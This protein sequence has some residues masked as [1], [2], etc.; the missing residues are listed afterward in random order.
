MKGYKSKEKRMKILEILYE[1]KGKGVRWKTIRDVLRREFKCGDSSIKY[2]LDELIREGFVEKVRRGE[3]KITNLGINEYLR[4]KPPVEYISFDSS[5]MDI[6]KFNRDTKDIAPYICILSG[7]FEKDINEKFYEY[8]EGIKSEKEKSI[9]SAYLDPNIGIDTIFVVD[10][11]EK[12]FR[13]I[14]SMYNYNL[15]KEDTAKI[16]KSITGMGAEFVW[17]ILLLKANEFL[18]YLNAFTDDSLKIFEIFLLDLKNNKGY[19]SNYVKSWKEFFNEIMQ[20]PSKLKAFDISSII[21][22]DPIPDK[23]IK[24]LFN[25]F[26]EKIEKTLEEKDAVVEVIFLPHEEYLNLFGLLFK[27]Y[28]GPN[29]YFFIIDSRRVFMDVDH[30]KRH[31]DDIVLFKFTE[32]VFRCIFPNASKKEIFEKI[33]EFLEK[34]FSISRESLKKKIK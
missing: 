32:A 13:I 31:S 17:K 15:F 22:K 11:K 8:Y 16:I 2:N 7:Y 29:P 3:Y 23:R 4:K 21:I 27:E 9:E 12:I 1:N 33:S 18:F 5:D 24:E 14:C 34:E 26:R 19:A 20:I 28:R 10:Q 25:K 30:L 6:L